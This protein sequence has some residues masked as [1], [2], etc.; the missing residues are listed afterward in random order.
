[1]MMIDEAAALPRESKKNSVFARPR[2]LCLHG[3][4]SNPRLV[5]GQAL[6]VWTIRQGS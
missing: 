2:E 4:L 1:M 5:P 6:L 3:G